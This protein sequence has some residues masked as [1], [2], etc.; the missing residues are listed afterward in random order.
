MMP[1]EDVYLAKAQRHVLAAKAKAMIR[2]EVSKGCTP[3]I[4][5]H[6]VAL[7]PFCRAWARP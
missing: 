7:E 2:A 4:A 6:P 5:P 1:V 3:E